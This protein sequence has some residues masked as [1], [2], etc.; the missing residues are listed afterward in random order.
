M[1]QILIELHQ[2][3]EALTQDSTLRITDIELLNRIQLEMMSKDVVK[4]VRKI[5]DL[6][7]KSSILEFL[8]NLKVVASSAS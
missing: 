1:A 6:I 8:S 4:A 7:A 3:L 2:L 5:Y